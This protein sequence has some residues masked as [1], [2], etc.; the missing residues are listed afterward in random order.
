MTYLKLGLKF[1]PW[2]ACAIL[3]VLLWTSYTAHG[4]TKTKLT[5]SAT[6]LRSAE[7]SLLLA[8]KAL[9][10]RDDAI[11]TQNDSIE[12]LRA[13]AEQQRQRYSVVV[14]EARQATIEGRPEVQELL[15]LKGPEG[16][17]EQC[18]ASRELIIKELNLR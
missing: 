15:G 17:L 13:Q 10:D 11:K 6:A 12:K 9:T 18:R 8:T 4:A 3:S 14:R 1:G 5:A 16:E 2:I 7:G